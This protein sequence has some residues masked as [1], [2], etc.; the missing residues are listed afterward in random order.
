MGERKISIEIIGEIEVNYIIVKQRSSLSLLI[1]A[2]IMCTNVCT[3][4]RNRRATL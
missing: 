1:V 3:A 2:E 4:D